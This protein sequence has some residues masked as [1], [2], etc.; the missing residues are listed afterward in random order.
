MFCKMYREN[1]GD[2]LK[3]YYKQKQRNNFVYKLEKIN[4]IQNRS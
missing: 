3:R 2:I 1:E 4:F